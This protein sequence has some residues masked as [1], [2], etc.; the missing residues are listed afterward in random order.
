[1]QNSTCVKN[2][3]CSKVFFLLTIALASISLGCGAPQNDAKGKSDKLTL[4]WFPEVEHGGY[5]QAFVVDAPELSIEV[6]GG[7]PDVPVIQKVATG[8]STFGV[9]NADDVINAQAQGADVV[10]IYAPLQS[11]PRCIMLRADSGITKMEDLKNITLAMSSRPAFSHW[12]R[13]R[14]PLENVQIVP[15]PGSIAPFT[16]RKDF[17]QQAYNI[18]EPFLAKSAGVETHLI[19]VS[20]LGF[21]PYGS[22]LITR[23]EVLKNQGERVKTIVA[24]AKKGWERYLQDAQAAHQVIHKLNPEMGLDILNYGHREVQKLCKLPQGMS[25]GQMSLER[26]QKLIDS[27]VECKLIKAGEV[28][29]QACFSLDYL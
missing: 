5:Y 21:N 1:M 11:H 10:A 25:D 3:V 27:M 18:S 15:Y 9:V 14:Y 24:A 22:V 13:H 7:G 12:L 16:Q 26:W 29:A 28:Q 4:N 8:A 23:R 6:E 19:M 2:F 17:A 20:E